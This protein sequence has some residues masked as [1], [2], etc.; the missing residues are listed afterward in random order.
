MLISKY[1]VY[2]VV[3]SFMGWIYET[4]YCTI[5]GGKWEN[6]G[7]LYGPI[8]PIYGVGADGITIVTDIISYFNKGEANYEWW[9]VFVISFFGSIVLEYVT[10][11]VLEKQFHAVWWDYSNIPLNIHGRVCLPASIGFGVAGL[12]VV[13]FI[14]PFTAGMSKA[15]PPLAMEGLSLVFMSLVTIDMTLTVNA[16]TNFSHYVIAFEDELNAHMDAFVNGIQEKSSDMSAKFAEERERFTLENAKNLVGTT[17]ELYHSALK[18]V[19]TFKYPRIEAPHIDVTLS[20]FKNRLGEK[21]EAV[22]KRIE[23]K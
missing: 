9:H 23:R 2:F 10:S 11:W 14:A 12:L 22:K 20:A 5:K 19:H 3:F 8:C 17:G 6:R 16:L 18:R 21:G 1:F 7:F 13:Y 15:I 4:I